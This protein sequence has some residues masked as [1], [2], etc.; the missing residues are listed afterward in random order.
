MS[1]LDKI[2]LTK[3]KEVSK[4]NKDQLEYARQIF[5]KSSQNNGRFEKALKNNYT[6]FEKV[7]TTICLI[8]G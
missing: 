4:L 7:D 5:L 8:K 3:M 1:I 6:I 2:K